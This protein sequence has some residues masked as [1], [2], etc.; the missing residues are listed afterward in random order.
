VF[1]TLLSEPSRKGKSVC[2]VYIYLHFTLAANILPYHSITQRSTL[3]AAVQRQG[4]PDRGQ[5]GAGD[6]EA[7][8]TGEHGGDALHHPVRLQEGL[9]RRPVAGVAERR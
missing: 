3:K 7:S 1:Y 8:G 2:N 4:D 6:L 9:D 5:L